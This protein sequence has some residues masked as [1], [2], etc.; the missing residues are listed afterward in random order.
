[1]QSFS[2]YLCVR[3]VAE[4]RQSSF[5]QK[6]D[7]ALV[8]SIVQATPVTRVVLKRCWIGDTPITRVAKL[9]IM[10]QMTLH[11]DTNDDETIYDKLACWCNSNGYKKDG[12][13]AGVKAIISDLKATIAL[14]YSSLLQTWEKT[15][16]SA[17]AQDTPVTCVVML[18]EKT[19]DPSG[20]QDTPVTR[21]V[22]LLEMI[23]ETPPRT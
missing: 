13:I 14:A 4:I 15:M 19:L 8:S 5:L 22:K 6:W 17:G 7:E 2:Q 18:R 23:Q 9:L 16:D 10:I 20:A 11:K 1:M 3:H 12:A 21:V